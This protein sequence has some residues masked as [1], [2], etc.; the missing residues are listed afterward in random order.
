M[1][2]KI[3]KRN[4][5]NNHL[6]LTRPRRPRFGGK[7]RHHRPIPRPALLHTQPPPKPVLLPQPRNDHERMHRNLRALP[8]RPRRLHRRRFRGRLAVLNVDVH[9]RAGLSF[10][11]RPGYSA[12]ES[13]REG[14][15]LEGVHDAGCG[16]FAD[17]AEGFEFGV[18]LP[19][20]HVTF[21]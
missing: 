15:E 7:K 12:G 16:D 5:Q 6:Q 8:L 13:A 21:P 4:K 17:E 1:Q 20:P 2:C 11:T 9:R 18:E 10:W 19:Y 14:E 3:Q